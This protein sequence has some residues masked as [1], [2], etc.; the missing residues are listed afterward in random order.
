[1][2]IWLP[3]KEQILHLDRMRR[4]P[5][6]RFSVTGII[7]MALFPATGHADLEVDQNGN[8]W[9]VCLGIRPSC[10]PQR[11]LKLH[12]LGRETFLS[13]VIWDKEGW[14]VVG[15]D[16]RIA[17]E[18]KGTTSRRPGAADMPGFYR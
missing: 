16:G 18:M 17:L 4:V 9:L 6:I 7:R 10:T 5:I 15:N 3:C 8:W 13:P 11:G 2:D 14:P 1:M 12:H